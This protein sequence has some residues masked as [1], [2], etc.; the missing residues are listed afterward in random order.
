MNWISVEDK[1]PP[2]YEYE[3]TWAY[4]KKWGVL[5]AHYYEESRAWSF[6]WS[7]HQSILLEDVTHWMPIDEPEPP[8]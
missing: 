1:M 6:D 2:E 4:S 5:Q 7:K 3:M 8:K